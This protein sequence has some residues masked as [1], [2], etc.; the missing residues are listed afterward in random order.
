VSLISDIL[1]SQQ[2]DEDQ[3]NSP[4]TADAMLSLASSVPASVYGGL[5]GLLSLGTGSLPPIEAAK[6]ADAT[7]TAHTYQP[8]TAAG[9]AAL[10][11]LLATSKHFVQKVG[12]ALTSDPEFGAPARAVA[13]IA[14]STADAY[15]NATAVAKMALPVLGAVAPVAK[16][17]GLLGDFADARALAAPL[18]GTPEGAVPNIAA[19]QAAR[20]YT[21][22]AGIPYNPPDAVT[23]V[24][25]DIGKEIADAYAA[26]QHAPDDPQVAAAYDAMIKETLAQHQHVKASGLKFEFIPPDMEDP[27][28]SGPRAAIDD[29]NQN[30][31][32][33][34]YPTD[35]GFGTDAAF[36]ASDNPLM[37]M[38]DEVDANGTPMRANDVFRV[39]HDY[40]GHVQHG[41]GFRAAGEEAAWRSHAG[42]YSPLA[43]RAMTS[44]TRG[45]NSWVN[46]GPNGEANRTASTP[47]T[48]FADQKTGLLPEKYSDLPT[49]R[50]INGPGTRNQSGAVSLDLS[51]MD[52]DAREAL[53][54]K[55]ARLTGLLATTPQPKLAPDSALSMFQA[56]PGSYRAAIDTKT[57][58]A[59][60]QRVYSPDEADLQKRI[61]AAG[62][63]S[64]DMPDVWDLNALT[65]Q[66]LQGL[67][68]PTEMH[69]KGPPDWLARDL[70]PKALRQWDKFN[71][72]ATPGAQDWFKTGQLYN[73]AAAEG[74]TSY[75]DKFLRDFGA[76]MG[77]TTSDA[78]PQANVRMASY[79]MLRRDQGIP[80]PEVVP[81]PFGHARYAST[82]SAVLQ[83]L[84]NN[85]LINSMTNPKGAHFA[86]NIDGMTDQ[87]TLDRVVAENFP[88]R[89]AGGKIL[90]APA[91]KT[92]GLV[93]QFMNDAAAKRGLLGKEYQAGGWAGH[94]PDT[95]DQYGRPLLGHVSDRINLMSAI[96]GI[97]AQKVKKM[98]VQRQIYL[99]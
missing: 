25:P 8:R 50:T 36:D 10:S 6:L 32:L 87:P 59:F 49:P 88:L 83:H 45:Q 2:A 16:V 21:A 82:H 22:E 33:W 63:A 97:P 51:G 15:P 90:Q 30:N 4:G 9:A 96:T 35:S 71:A 18:E 7:T 65:N 99:P 86:G 60:A 23:P 76:T 38:T 89:S 13:D 24:N 75:A 62:K 78:T 77:A 94:N 95:L 84:D 70:T 79:H 26:M 3:N 19:R 48:V 80:T 34:V 57:G 41:N 72:R 68:L 1:Q 17:A 58:K 5:K 14:R 52:P 81:Y 40:F 29:V 73:D 91:D 54:A 27:Y 47:D 31:H 61:T 64:Q 39:V 92:Y 43:R 37:Q 67:T 98:W 20:D 53:E 44:E 12:N 85:D 66:P 56:E 55:A 74:G 69:A 11:G 42:M 93:A 28:A 46:F